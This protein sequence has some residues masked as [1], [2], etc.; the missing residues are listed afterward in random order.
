MTGSLHSAPADAPARD[1]AERILAGA[2]DGVLAFDA[3]LRYTY[4]NPAMERITGVRAEALLGREITTAFPPIREPGGLAR[5]RA[6]LA[7]ESV[8]TR[9]IEHVSPTTGQVG[10]FDSLFS[11]I[12]DDDG[13]TI[14]GMAVVRDVTERVLAERAAA[15]RTSELMALER[16]ARELAEIANRTKADFLAVMSHELRTPL[17]AISG[18][19]E[20]L[21]MGVRGPLTPQQREDLTRIQRSQHHLLSLINDV[22]NFAKLEAGRVEYHLCEVN[23]GELLDS[24]EPLVRPQ[25][26]ERGLEF[27]PCDASAAPAAL[28]DMEKLRQ[29]LLNLL[30]NA[31]KFTPSGGRISIDCSEDEASVRIA[32]ADTGVGIAADKLDDIFEPFVQLQRGLTSQHE[33]TGLGLAISRDLARGMGGELVVRSGIGTGST[34]TLTL[35]RA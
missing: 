21:L 27:S 33:G 22:L 12:R 10:Y 11:P 20:L 7:G 34:F 5:Y 29:I 25:L 19:T 2:T 17:N 1:T 31:V 24:I 9:E 15:A 13:R 28:A 16:H 32:V 30:S 8:A 35:P 18:Y 3:Q 6:T 23:V 26:L 4:W 14:G